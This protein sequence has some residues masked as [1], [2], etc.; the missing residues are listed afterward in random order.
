MNDDQKQALTRI[1]QAAAALMVAAKRFDPRHVN[2]GPVHQQAPVMTVD[3]ATFEW[4]ENGVRCSLDEVS[5]ESPAVVWP[6]M[7][8]VARHAR[9]FLDA[10]EQTNWWRQREVLLPSFAVQALREAL[11]AVEWEEVEQSGVT[12]DPEDALLALDE[13]DQYDSHTRMLMR[14]VVVKLS[15][16]EW[17]TGAWLREVA[18]EAGFGTLDQ[19]RGDAISLGMLGNGLYQRTAGAS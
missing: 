8:L 12:V 15:A 17:P 5:N 7:Q 6:A 18:T 9:V 11:D 10:I 2:L 13:M 3:V 16:E 14:N 19:P 4:L 1:W